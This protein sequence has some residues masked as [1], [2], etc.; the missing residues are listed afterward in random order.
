MIFGIMV[1][2]I[3]KKCR[4]LIEVREEIP[5]KAVKEFEYQLITQNSELFKILK[6]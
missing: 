6:M 3:K 4:F 2:E 5:K 1:K